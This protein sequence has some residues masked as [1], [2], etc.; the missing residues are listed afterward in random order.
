MGNKDNLGHER[1][2][3]KE[4]APKWPPELPPSALLCANHITCTRLWEPS[5]ECPKES[6][7][8]Q[9]GEVQPI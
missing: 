7:K 8:Q 5:S 6:L 9:D 1:S 4:R 3:A 2:P